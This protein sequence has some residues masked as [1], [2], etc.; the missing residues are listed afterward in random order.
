[1]HC[2]SQPVKLLFVSLILLYFILFSMKNIYMFASYKAITSKFNTSILLSCS[3]V[4]IVLYYYYLYL[5]HNLDICDITPVLVRDF[6]FFYG[7]NVAQR[8]V[9]IWKASSSFV[10]YLLY[11]FLF[12][13]NWHSPLEEYV[14]TV[15]VMSAR[16]IYEKTSD[17]LFISFF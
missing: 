1:M 15:F 9:P 6:F 11:H 3:N 2:R 12:L 16:A 17:V 5:M 10:Y 8:N 4:T 7:L 13:T 14:I